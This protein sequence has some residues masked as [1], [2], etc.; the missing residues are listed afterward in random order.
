MCLYLDWDLTIDHTILTN[1]TAMVVCDF[2]GPGPY[3]MYSLQVVTKK[4]IPLNNSP[5]T[6]IVMTS[7]NDTRPSYNDYSPLS[8]CDTINVL[9]CSAPPPR[10]SIAIASVVTHA[11]TPLMYR[12]AS[13]LRLALPLQWH[14][15]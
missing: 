5:C 15:S 14:L 2:R 3:L 8:R 7:V 6:F 9:Q 13:L 1:F 10:P 12:P 11:H 4:P